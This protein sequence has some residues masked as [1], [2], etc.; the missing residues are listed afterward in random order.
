[1]MDADYRTPF[2]R[3]CR[4]PGTRCNAIMEMIERG[5]SDAEIANHLKRTPG[6]IRGMN[7]N[8]DTD[9]VT[10]S[11]YRKALYGK[12]TEASGEAFRKD[13]KIGDGLIRKMREQGMTIKAIASAL[14][15]THGQVSHRV[16]PERKRRHVKKAKAPENTGGVKEILKDLGLDE[17]EAARLL[18]RYGDH[19]TKM[20]V[21]D[22]LMDLLKEET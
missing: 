7:P 9:A 12:L 17:A 14:G 21:M 8:A 22:M 6:R 15:L 2:E 1:M 3:M 19:E 5:M 20:K 4:V 10:I 13:E 11:V 16:R 18:M